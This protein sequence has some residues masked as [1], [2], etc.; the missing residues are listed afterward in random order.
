MGE[1]VGVVGGARRVDG[2]AKAFDNALPEYAPLAP[3]A[4]FLPE[5]ITAQ[6]RRPTTLRLQQ[7][8]LRRKIWLPYALIG[9]LPVLAF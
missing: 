9:N 8:V 2:P 7:P 5:T 3:A 6:S 4:R 1:A